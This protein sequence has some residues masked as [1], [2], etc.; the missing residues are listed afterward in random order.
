MRSSFK[1]DRI[2]H[3]ACLLFLD[4]DICLQLRSFDCFWLVS[5]FM[6]S[7]IHSGRYAFRNSSIPSKCPSHLEYTF[8]KC[9]LI[10]CISLESVVRTLLVSILLVYVYSILFTSSVPFIPR[11]L[12]TFN[13]TSLSI[14][15]YLKKHRKHQDNPVS[16]IEI[17]WNES[18]N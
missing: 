15:L 10:F 17:Q 13:S 2:Q 16:P 5:L 8:W 18:R 4:G 14:V 12:N 9:S 11:I 3:W 7:G 6:S 1:V